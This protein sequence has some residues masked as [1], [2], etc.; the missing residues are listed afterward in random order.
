MR[1]VDAKTEMDAKAV[2]GRADE[3]E[4]NFGVPREATIEE[5]RE[6]ILRRILGEPN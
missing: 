1:R 4:R 2:L 5:L 3:Q 6:N